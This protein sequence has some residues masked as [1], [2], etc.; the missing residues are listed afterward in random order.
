V[1]VVDSSALIAII[2]KEPQGP[3][4]EMAL[5]DDDDLVISAGNLTE[6]LIVAGQRGLTA[7]IDALIEQCAIDVIA[8]DE[9][10]AR[11]AANAYTK[12]GK[13]N[14]PASLNY[15][16]CFAYALAKDRGCPLLFVGNDFGQTDI[17][18]AF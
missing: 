16:D 17:Q 14:H 15:G 3:L 13:G 5:T 18:S 11:R 4:C 9:A 12:W 10:T 8:V 1:I 7:E 6:A 2:M